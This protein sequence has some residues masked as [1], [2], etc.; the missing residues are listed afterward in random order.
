MKLTWR[1][2]GCAHRGTAHHPLGKGMV[3]APVV[4]AENTFRV[5]GY[6]VG[7]EGTYSTVRKAKKA[8][9]SIATNIFNATDL[10]AALRACSAVITP[11]LTARV[12]RAERAMTASL[13]GTQVADFFG[14]RR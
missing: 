14:A 12:A 6:G 10:L 11:D 7:F 8:A 2:R 3:V 4:G 13:N 9:Q 1:R 5:V